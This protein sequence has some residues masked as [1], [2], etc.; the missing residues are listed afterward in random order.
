[1]LP[2]FWALFLI[3]T[4]TAAFADTPAASRIVDRTVHYYATLHEALESATGISIDT[5]AEITI[6]AN[7]ILDTSIILDTAKHIRLVTADSSRT[8]RRGNGNLEYPL[9]WITG[10]S[11]TLTLGKPD[12]ENQLIIDGGYLQTPPIEALAP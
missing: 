4:A 2:K 9:L 6:L 5:P 8:I 1:M 12:M 7:I 10:D 11:A 3:L